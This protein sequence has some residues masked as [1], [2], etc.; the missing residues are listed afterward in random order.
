MSKLKELEPS[1]LR[2]AIALGYIG[3]FMGLLHPEIRQALGQSWN[4][5]MPPAILGLLANVINLTR[6]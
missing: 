3:G 4:C 1:W 6:D 2:L 5:L